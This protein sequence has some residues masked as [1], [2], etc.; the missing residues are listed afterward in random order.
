MKNTPNDGPV[1]IQ[2]VE[3][4]V[5]CKPYYEPTQYWEY[6]RQTGRAALGH[7]GE[8]LGQAGGVG[9]RRLPRPAV[10]ASAAGRDEMIGRNEQTR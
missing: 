5:I 8:P 6:D 2:P 3:S 9:F 1:L 4:P 10:V 7:G